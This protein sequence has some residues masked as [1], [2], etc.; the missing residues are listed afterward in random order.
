MEDSSSGPSA[1]P[2]NRQAEDTETEPETVY[3]QA[4][5]FKEAESQSHICTRSQTNSW[6][7]GEEHL[8]H[9]L[10]RESAGNQEPDGNHQDKWRQQGHLRH[11]AWCCQGRLPRGITQPY[12]SKQLPRLPLRYTDLWLV[13]WWPLYLLLIGFIYLFKDIMRTVRVRIFSQL[14]PAICR[15][16]VHHPPCVSKCKGKFQNN[17]LMIVIV[18]IV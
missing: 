7:Q 16:G 8:D 17:F 3:A 10:D 13:T 2:S 9:L 11:C 14:L 6:W 1:S 4:T 12:A 15:E 5:T 18:L